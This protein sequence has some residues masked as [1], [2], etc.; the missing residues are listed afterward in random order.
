MTSDSKCFS[1][2]LG[3]L[4]AWQAFWCSG[5]IFGWPALARTLKNEGQYLELCENVSVDNFTGCANQ[6]IQLNLIN[7]LGVNSLTYFMLF[8]GIILDKFGPR[9]ASCS[10]GFVCMLFFCFFFLFFFCD[11]F[12]HKH[13]DT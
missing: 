8:W 1:K 5:V 3:F 4:A 9:I 11:F 7:T 6:N 2:V 10:G 13:I 12:T